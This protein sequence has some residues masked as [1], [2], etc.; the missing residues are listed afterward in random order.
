MPLLQGKVSRAHPG[1]S[2]D[3]AAVEA[4]LSRRKELI[5]AALGPSR[6]GSLEEAAYVASTH[7][8]PAT[9]VAHAVTAAFSATAALLIIRNR[10]TTALSAGGKCFIPDFIRLMMT[11]IPASAVSARFALATDRAERYASGGTQFGFLPTNP[12]G[13]APALTDLDMFFG[14][15]VASAAGGNTRYVAQGYMRS[16]IPVV[17]DQWVFEFDGGDAG[18]A[19]DTAG[20]TAKIVSVRCPPIILEPNQNDRLILHQWYPSNATTPAQFEF[21]VGGWWL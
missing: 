18:N 19:Q 3:A 8:T 4:R 1:F 14:A 9:A 7:Q 21:T 15:V 11:V 2:A 17:L 6:F 13:S 20:S 16:V 12:G 10:S 5:V